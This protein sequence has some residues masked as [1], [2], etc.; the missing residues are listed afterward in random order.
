VSEP[1]RTFDAD[2]LRSALDELCERL[3][4]AEVSAGI[5]IV[6]GAAIALTVAPERIATHDIDVVI[7]PQSATAAVLHVVAEMAVARGWPNDWLSDAVRGFLPFAGD[8][9]WTTVRAA[10]QVEI[11]MAPADLLLAM[12]LH[13]AR[14]ARDASDIR[15]LLQATGTTSAGDAEALYERYYPGEVLKPRARAVVAA[16]FTGS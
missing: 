14:G 16:Y 5:C 3:V 6:G 10:G 13:A 15:V 12:K 9:G 1:S 4:D 11:R 2:A 7:Y 8:P